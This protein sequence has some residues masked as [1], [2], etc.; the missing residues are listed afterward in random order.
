LL[1]TTALLY[2]FTHSIPLNICK[3]CEMEIKP[4][5]GNKTSK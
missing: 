1:G 4:Q 2:T 5:R 3:T